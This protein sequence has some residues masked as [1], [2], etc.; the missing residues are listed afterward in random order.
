MSATPASR[1]ATCAAGSRSCSPRSSSVTARAKDASEPLCLEYD[2]PPRC[3]LIGGSLLWERERDVAVVSPFQ[4]IAAQRIEFLTGELQ[5]R[6]LR[7]LPAAAKANASGDVT[8]RLRTEH[9][10]LT[11]SADTAECAV[12]PAQLQDSGPPALTALRSIKASAGAGKKVILQGDAIQAEAGELDYDAADDI[13]LLKGPDRQRF[14][15]TGTA[16]ADEL[17]AQTVTG[18]LQGR[19]L[20]ASRE[21]VPGMSVTVRSPNLLGERGAITDKDGFFQVLALPPGTYT[22]R[23][24]RVGLRSVE[25]QE[26]QVALG[27]T[28]NLGE[29]RTQVEPVEMEA[30][31]VTAGAPSIP[32]P[33]RL[34]LAIGGRLIIPVG[35]RLTQTLV[36]V[37]RITERNFR[38]E[39]LLGCRF[40]PLVGDHGWREE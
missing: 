16:G 6:E 24:G 31:V 18:N 10:E 22:V 19:M 1:T 21:P 37:T 40:V 2:G 34:Q 15:Y 36:R 26:V 32:E 7:F 5:C 23:L 12:D 33:Y 11:I 20:D 28:T 39:R 4:D 9:G 27:R 14:R 29:L 8:I 38:E 3:R 13:L 17:A 25:V 35:D 30:L